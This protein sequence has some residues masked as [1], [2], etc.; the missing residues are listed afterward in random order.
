MNSTK[1]VL[2]FGTT[3]EN[4]R[5]SGKTIFNLNRI[6]IA[7]KFP[8]ALTTQLQAHSTLWQ[9]EIFLDTSSLIRL[10]GTAQDSSTQSGRMRVCKSDLRKNCCLTQM[11]LITT[12]QFREI[13]ASGY[14]PGDGRE[15]AIIADLPAG[16]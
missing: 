16:N 10:L 11:L 13:Q 9:L 1:I 6:F 8:D 7:T 12:N 2:V 4:L 5:P 14:A 15:S 3:W